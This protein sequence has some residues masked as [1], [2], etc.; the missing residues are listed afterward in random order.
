MVRTVDGG[1]R[2]VY[3]DE[4]IAGDAIDPENLKRL[5]KK[6]FLAEATATGDES[7]SGSAKPPTIKEI[8][9]DV[10]DDKA[11]AQEALDA[12][13][14]RG[15]DARPSLVEKLQAVIAAE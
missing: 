1:Y 3:Q 10:G 13:Q 11:K 14:A 7:D 8:M 15:D 5:V 4:P 12:E 9:A 2:H 6:G